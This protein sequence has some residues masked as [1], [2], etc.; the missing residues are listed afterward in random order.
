MVDGIRVDVGCQKDLIFDG[1][2]DVI[3]DVMLIMMSFNF[4][5][6]NISRF[7]PEDSGFFDYRGKW[8]HLNFLNL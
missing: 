1:E 5:V 7:T 8:I 3:F 4:C 2:N 6:K